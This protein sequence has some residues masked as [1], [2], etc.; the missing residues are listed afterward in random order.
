[1]N[2]SIRIPILLL[3]LLTFNSCASLFYGSSDKVRFESEPSGAKVFVN[4]LDTKR[5]TPCEINVVKEKYT[6][7]FAWTKTFNYMNYEL[8]LD[9]Y[10]PVKDV[11]HAK[12]HAFFY[13]DFICLMVLVD[14]SAKRV[15]KYN[16]TLNLK[17]I[18]INSSS[19]K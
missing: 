10:T 19:N 4:G 5:T 17:L 3:L 14:I 8:K 16:T 1:M 7:G 2:K 15:Y 12:K 18:P 6:R 11:I 13:P 9:G